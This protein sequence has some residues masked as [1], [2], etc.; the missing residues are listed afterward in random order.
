[1]RRSLAALSLW[2]Q[3]CLHDRD[4]QLPFLTRTT[5]FKSNSKSNLLRQRSAWLLALLV[6]IAVVGFV[7]ISSVEAHAELERSDPAENGLLGAPP[8]KID[9][10]FTET[11]DEGAGSPSLSVL[12][13]N[14]TE[15]Q[16]TNLH[17]DPADRRHVSA[18]LGGASLDSY[19]VVWSARS[20]EDGHT[21]SGSYTFRVA[22]GRAPGA[23]T[24]EGETPR[25]WAVATRWLTFLGASIAAAG[26]L[27]RVVLLGGLEPA[28]IRDRR[29]TLIFI[30]SFV[31]LVATSVEPW[32]QV[33]FPPQ[34]ATAPDFNDAV[35]GLPNGWW[36]RLGAAGVVM[37]VSLI[38]DFFG[39]KMR[40]PEILE[41]IGA[42]AASCVLLGLSLT[43]HA[44]ARSSWRAVAIASDFVHQNAV[45]LWVGGLVFLALYWMS[46][47]EAVEGPDPIRRFSRIALV[48]VTVGVASGVANAGFVFPAVRSLWESDYGK[49]L[50]VKVMV[51]FPALVLAT[52]H[53]LKLRQA[54]GDLSNALRST[55]RL[56]TVIV[57]A[58]VLG[59]T[60]LALM[61]PPAKAITGSAKLVDLAAPGMSNPS[62]SGHLIRFQLAPARSGEDTITVF[63]TDMNGQPILNDPIALA[64]L[65]LTSLSHGATALGLEGTPNGSGGFTF[66]GDQ[67]SLN[68][69]WRADI[70]VRRLSV[71]DETASFY[72]MLPDPNVNGFSAPGKPDSSDD[73]EALYQRALG[74]FA[75][76][77]SMAYTQ[78]LSGGTGT[79]F[80]SDH[81]VR[82]GDG[83]LDPAMSVTSSSTSIVAIGDTQWIKRGD[84]DWQMQPA[85]PIVP[86][87]QWGDTYEGSTGY[88]L[89]I[90]EEINGEQAQIVYFYLPPTEGRIAAWFAWWV[91]IDSGHVLRETMVSRSH[92]M[93]YNYSR[94]NEDF[95]IQPP[96]EGEATPQG[97]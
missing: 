5:S 13:E 54:A 29:A 73:A 96:V 50:I 15:L 32:L 75:S 89:G 92:Y 94:F 97:A 21:L 78:R 45:G 82:D 2:S 1:L 11:V 64:R 81:L 27:F 23:A 51:L 59:G 46:W 44:S 33:Q 28:A 80:D 62:P 17:V 95:D 68:G 55:V 85:G 14:G 67:L 16:I 56:E 63:V 77:H 3:D 19:T 65:D 35:A 91:G 8:Q 39:E 41:G 34:G 42:V 52:M 9:L 88:Q 4:K 69:W 12:D 66:K 57:A 22:T 87:S 90:T 76:L 26:F 86:P 71:E 40:Q 53:R 6:L 31:A 72:F 58:V 93:V 20:A 7:R 36:L 24:T 49:I 70:L 38:Y 48:L 83:G 30:G 84:A 37:A 47:H 43:S 79:V 60:V 10:W 18:D 61:A 25:A 74:T